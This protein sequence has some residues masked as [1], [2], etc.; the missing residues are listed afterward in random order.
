MRKF[1]LGSLL[2]VH[3]ILASAGGYQVNLVGI[4]YVGMGH[5][6]TALKLDATSIFYNPGSLSL[7]EPKYSFT[8]GVSGIFSYSA[9]Q[10]QNSSYVARA[11]NH[12]TT[13]FSIFGSA[14]ITE[15]LS[16]GI[17]VYTPFGSRLEWDKE[18][19]GR[20]LIQEIELRAIFVQPTVS[21]KIGDKLGIG[22]GLVYGH[23]SV[24]LSRA[25]PISDA[26]GNEGSVTLDGNTHAWGF[27]AG[28]NLQATEKLNIGVSY[29]SKLTM[30]VKEGDA[31]FS[32]PASLATSF[33]AN[34]KFTAS[35][36]L[37]SNLN[38]GLAY[39]CSDKFML[40][41][42]FNYVFWSTY[43]NLDFDFKENTASLPD[44]KNPRNFNNGYIV[45]LGAN[46]KVS[47][48]FDIRLGAYFDKA[49]SKDDYITPE[50]PD[51]NKI[52]LA[53]GLSVMPIEG[54]SIDA[55]FLFIK[56]L[57]RDAQYIPAGFGGTYKTNA[58]VP[59]LGLTYN[60]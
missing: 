55:S 26:N 21:Y 37:P 10:Y 3:S 32:A 13:P 44:S 12:V 51:I 16:A 52:G 6:G 27:N 7:I 30:K 54:L 22:A 11:K 49:P 17:G 56:G 50:T 40:G 59:G 31:T 25:L 14:K 4:R 53:A 58:L 48:A 41:L 18:W 5:I 38:A 1:L 57:A 43:E 8:G 47:S 39:Q 60:F 2:I 24:N 35:L 33:P 46:Y 42:D 36:P 19:R 29:R 45:R 23:G 9:F 15:N 28:I 20:Y 34:N